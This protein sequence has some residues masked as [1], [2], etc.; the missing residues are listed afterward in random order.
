LCF[1]QKKKKKKKKTQH[2]VS[3]M[4]GPASLEDQCA[5]VLARHLSQCPPLGDVPSCVVGS[6]AAALARPAAAGLAAVAAPGLGPDWLAIATPAAPLAWHFRSAGRCRSMRDP[7]GEPPA[8]TVLCAMC[9]LARRGE[10]VL[11]AEAEGASSSSGSSNNNNNNNNNNSNNNSCCA[12]VSVL[13][14][15]TPEPSI[16]GI[17]GPSA[18]IDDDDGS[19]SPV[20]LST[21]ATSPTEGSSPGDDGGSASDEDVQSEDVAS[22]GVPSSL[23]ICC[24]VVPEPP[25][26]VTMVLRT[27]QLELLNT[28]G[29]CLTSAVVDA[30]GALRPDDDDD[31]DDDDNVKNTSSPG[32]PGLS[33]LNTGSGYGWARGQGVSGAGLHGSISGTNALAGELTSPM[34]AA[35]YD[36]GFLRNL[37]AHRA[38]EHLRIV[39]ALPPRGSSKDTFRQLHRLRRLRIDDARRI[40]AFQ[41]AVLPPTLEELWLVRPP[42]G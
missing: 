27:R 7:R 33:N 8:A 24:C 25:A 10:I 6:V 30:R 2:T 23:Q 35:P 39:S 16:A 21:G 19:A 42:L 37:G 18:Y 29:A 14:E 20:S 11:A 36:P 9:G 34:A 26:P 40:T 38:L 31:D 5:R 22:A 1:F 28:V 17:A 15:T 41:L 12:A 4:A 13:A 32:G 3:K